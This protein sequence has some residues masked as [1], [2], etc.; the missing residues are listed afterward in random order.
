MISEPTYAPSNTPF[1]MTV[2]EWVHAYWI[3]RCVYVVAK[4]GI[5]DL[6]KD[7]PQHCDTLAALTNTHSDSLYR[8]LRSLAGVGIFAETQPRCFK[9]TPLADCLKSNAPD[10]VRAM[11]ILR[12]AE[13]YH[14]AWGDL[15]YS[16]QTGESAFERLYG[17]DLFQYNDRNPN[18]GEIFD[19]AMAESEE[20][21]P[22]V[23]AAYDFSS[24]GKLVDIGGGKGSLL[25]TILQA[26]PSMT[27]VLFDRPDVIDRAKNS[28]KTA[29]VSDR[30]QFVGGDFFQSVPKGD[31]YILKHIIQDWD[32]ERAIAILQRCHQA[33][34]P[35]GRLLV[36]D[37]VIPAGNEFCSSKFIDVNML[38]MC[39]GGRI[40]TEAEFRELFKSAGFKLTQIISTESEVNIIE[41]VK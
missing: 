38:V 19:R 14:Q 36:I 32:D 29:N 27:G 26:Y 4:L 25:T 33:M 10:S 2:I 28:P 34:N 37:F 24:I 30:C 39:P 41:G 13:H 7:K 3:S 12:G 8:I 23:L 11:A 6:L 18:Q 40:R 5:A 9:L 16:L 1:Q 21:N 31:A 17:I 15:M 22:L 35:Q 20:T